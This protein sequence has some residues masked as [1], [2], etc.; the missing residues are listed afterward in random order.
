MKWLK[1]PAH[2][3]LEVERNELGIEFDMYDEAGKKLCG[4]G[5]A[6]LLFRKKD[7]R[8]SYSSPFNAGSVTPQRGIGLTTGRNAL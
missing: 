4:S 2:R 8:D 3:V 6:Y 7:G 1:I 5:T